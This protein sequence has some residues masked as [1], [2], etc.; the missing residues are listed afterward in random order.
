M[1]EFI[2]RQAAKVAAGTKLD[3][4]ESGGKV[5]CVVITTPATYTAAVDDTIGSAVPIPIGA[6]FLSIGRVGN[7]A[8]ASS[9][10]L[11]V[12]LRNFETKAVIDEDGL[13]ATIGIQTAGVNNAANGF[14]F[15]NGIDSLTTQ[16]TEVYATWKGA[17]PT[18]NQQLRIEMYYSID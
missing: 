9:S 17:T 2:S 12:G 4:G 15:L 8:G 3:A 10:T 13:V 11:N 16:V 14:F 18:A 7:A 1:A 5:R 6:R